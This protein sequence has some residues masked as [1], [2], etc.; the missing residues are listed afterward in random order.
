MGS[1]FAIVI[2][3]TAALPDDL[4]RAHDVRWLPLKVILNDQ[5]FVAATSP[6]DA[7]K[8]THMTTDQFYERIRPKDVKP[9]TSAPNIEECLAVYDSAIAEGAREIL[10][11]TIATEL[12]ATYSVAATTAEQRQGEARIEVVDTRSLAGGISLIATACSR[13]RDRGGS[14]DEAV[15]LARRMAGAVHLLAAA[16]GLEYLRRSG[17]VS[18]G[19]ALFGTL[20]AVKPLL[21]V[22]NGAV[23]PIGKV[24]TRDKAVARLKELITQRT[25]EGARIH[26]CVLHTN[27]PDRARLLGEWVQERYHCVEYFLSEA[28]PVIG[29]RTG[30]GVIGLCWYPETPT[31]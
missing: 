25:P 8:P 22:A 16:D 26:A 19:A 3:G 12:S 23:H 13:L 27:D 20:L 9:E 10:V 7:G 4:V 31:A 18:G 21:D 30:P 6:A 24:R 11:L 2:D 5:A 29:A 28:G 14:F 1:R 15:A 17:R